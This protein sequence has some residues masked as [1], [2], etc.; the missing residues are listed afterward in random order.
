VEWGVTPVLRYDALGRLTRTD[1]PNGTFS[2]VVFDPW[3]QT[4]FDPND[5]V[6]PLDAKDTAGESLWYQA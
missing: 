1:L 6:A 4:T 3:K 2:R 5:N